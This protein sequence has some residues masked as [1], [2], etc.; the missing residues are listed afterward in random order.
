QP[1][2]ITTSYATSDDDA[3]GEE[4]V[5][6][7]PAVVDCAAGMV[8]ALGVRAGPPHAARTANAQN[9]RRR[10]ITERRARARTR[11]RRFERPKFRRRRPGGTSAR[12]DRAGSRRAAEK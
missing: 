7:A 3:A 8:T 4:R 10:V 2:R 5:G 11:S 12:L 6:Q 9:A 1:L